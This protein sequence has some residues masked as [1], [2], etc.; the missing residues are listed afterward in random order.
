MMEVDQQARKA[1]VQRTFG[2]LA[3]HGLR[4]IVDVHRAEIAVAAL[5][6]P[7]REIG[8]ILKRNRKILDCL[9]AANFVAWRAV[10]IP[11]GDFSKRLLIE[12]S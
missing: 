2:V 5:L 1:S 11:I 7:S 12:H 3:S 10:R 9:M 6:R 4:R 8:Q